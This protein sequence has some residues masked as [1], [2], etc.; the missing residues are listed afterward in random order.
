MSFHTFERNFR[1]RDQR[2]QIMFYFTLGEIVPTNSAQ[3]LFV[4]PV[5]RNQVPA[6][7]QLRRFAA[8]VGHALLFP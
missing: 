3:E 1:P 5:D 4:G 6:T 8:I 2:F 7:W